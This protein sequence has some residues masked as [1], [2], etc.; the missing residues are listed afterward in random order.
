VAPAGNPLIDMVV[1]FGVP[2]DLVTVTVNVALPAVPVVS[3]PDWALTLTACNDA[4][5]GATTPTIAA[6]NV[7]ASM[8]SRARV[9]AKPEKNLFVVSTVISLTRYWQLFGSGGSTRT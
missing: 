6:T 4:N 5:A 8:A 2:L 1:V 9:A 7:A 3:V